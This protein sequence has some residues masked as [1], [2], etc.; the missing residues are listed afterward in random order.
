MGC[1][2]SIEAKVAVE[3][4]RQIDRNLRQDLERQT[5][6]VKLLLLGAGESGLSKLQIRLMRTET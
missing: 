2:Q 6:E 3:K 4:S 5:K 1:A